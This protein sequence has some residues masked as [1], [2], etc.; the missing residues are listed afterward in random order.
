MTN[1]KIIWTWAPRDSPWLGWAQ[2]QPVVT[3][4]KKASIDPGPKRRS[5]KRRE[6][7]IRRRWGLIFTLANPPAKTLSL[8]N[9]TFTEK[10]FQKKHLLEASMKM[11]QTAYKSCLF[12]E[13]LEDHTCLATTESIAV[14]PWLFSMTARIGGGRVEIL[15]RIIEAQP[16]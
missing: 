11:S 8:N 3:G 15:S 10:P 4:M 5:R 1:L 7:R 9:H 12:P 13:Y 2:E 16:R 14:I 6:M